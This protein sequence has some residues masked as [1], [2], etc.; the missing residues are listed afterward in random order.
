MTTET[1]TFTPKAELKKGVFLL[2]RAFVT[3][4]KGATHLIDQSLHRYPY[5]WLLLIL[6]ATCIT[7]FVCIGKARAE[8]DR[9]NKQNYELQ[10]KV[11]SLSNILEAR[12]GAGE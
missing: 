9:L 2:G 5:P 3:I 4:F 7:S 1:I 8:R 6:L 12:K 10:Q 11:E